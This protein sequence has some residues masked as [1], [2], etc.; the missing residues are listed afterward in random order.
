MENSQ[1]TNYS[2]TCSHVHVVHYCCCNGGNS[3][4]AKCKACFDR[5]AIQFTKNV[6][7]DIQ[8]VTC[9]LLIGCESVLPKTYTQLKVFTANDSSPDYHI[10]IS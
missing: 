1:V 6:L 5:V 4:D 3:W 7:L 8:T 10:I 2:E 9:S